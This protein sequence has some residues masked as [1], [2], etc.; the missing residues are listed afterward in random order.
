MGNDD[1]AIPGP[2]VFAAYLRGL[3]PG[4]YCGKRQ[5]YCNCPISEWLKTVFPSSLSVEVDIDVITV[6]FYECAE[7]VE[8]PTWAFEFVHAL[9]TQEDAQYLSN[10]TAL[11]AL[12]V[13]KT[14]L[15]KR[16]G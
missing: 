3:G 16:E 11:E 12:Q 10:V 13:L 5:A 15:A 2:Q 14:V 6:Y 4:H 7:E 8:T 9:D 1:F